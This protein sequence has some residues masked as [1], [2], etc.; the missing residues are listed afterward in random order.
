MSSQL[1]NRVRRFFLENLEDRLA[2]A[3]TLI[4]ASYLP[5]SNGNIYVN[6]QTNQAQLNVVKTATAG[7]YQINDGVQTLTV[8]NVF[9]NITVN[10]QTTNAATFAGSFSGNGTTTGNVNLTFSRLSGTNPVNFN[11]NASAAASILGN[12]TINTNTANASTVTL[13][14]GSATTVFG[15][16]TI[17]ETGGAT[18]TKSVTRGAG[19]AALTVRGNFYAPNINALSFLNGTTTVL[20]TATV[21][22]KATTT[23]AN[24][25]TFGALSTVGNLSVNMGNVLGAGSSTLTLS[26]TVNGFTTIVLGTNDGANTQNVVNLSSGANF[27]GSL[28][29]I[30]GGNGGKQINVQG[31]NAGNARLYVTLGNALDNQV[32]FTGTNT[33]VSA[34]LVGGTGINT[35]T[36]TV[37]FPLTLFRFTF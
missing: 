27:N 8:N 4:G 20:G 22:T 17:N 28:I 30:Q 2:P 18:A 10:A 3:I 25:V 16:L 21:S 37:N 19:T 7:Q 5:D 6:L 9:G 15:N 26:G 11:L 34:T 13:N 1:K 23:I 36:G 33:L 31:I 14:P 35:V 24:A 12:L 32:N 29:S